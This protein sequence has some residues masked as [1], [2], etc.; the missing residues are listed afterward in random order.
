MTDLRLFQREFGAHFEMPQPILDALDA[1]TLVDISWHNDVCPSFVR[2][3]DEELDSATRLWVSPANP[4][5]REYPEF[6]HFGVYDH[7]GNGR[8]IIETDDVEIA[9]AHLLK[10]A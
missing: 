9:L 8:S 2:A 10:E 4:E 7:S 6:K 3:G 1:G 5:D